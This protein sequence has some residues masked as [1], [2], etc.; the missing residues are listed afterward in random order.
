MPYYDREIIEEINNS[1]SILELMERMGEATRG[2]GNTVS[3][4]CPKCGG[5]WNNSRINTQKNFFKCFR[6]ESLGDKFQ[7]KAINYIQGKFNYSLV[8]A[9]EFL[10][11][12]YRLNLSSKQGYS[13]EEKRTFDIL[14]ETFKFY[15]RCL[16]QS[17][18]LIKRGISK[19]VLL[20]V[21]AG[22]APGGKMLTEHLLKKGFKLQELK[23]MSLVQNN[24]MDVVYKRVI[25]PI[26]KYG[27]PIN[28][29]TRRI[30]EEDYMKHCYYNREVVI[31]GHDDIQDNPDYIDIYEAPINQLVSRT[32]GFP[33][34][35]ATGGCNKFNE[36]HMNFIK[37]KKPKKGVRIIYDSDLNGQGQ[38]GAYQVSK[39]LTENS[40][41]NYVV[42]LPLGKDPANLLT[43]VNGKDKFQYCLEHAISGDEYQAHYIM[44]DMPIT[45]I[46]E[47]L[48]R[49]IEEPKKNVIFNSLFSIE[50]VHN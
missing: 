45:M 35:I 40:I 46:L 11:S 37:K 18:Y 12:E 42:M 39:K 20:K 23:D 8:E 29:Y 5:D 13:A 4:L 3:F 21:N 49:R 44:K 34:G 41:K 15:K 1:I 28:F 6:C 7:G 43:E 38:R 2:R 25:L 30:D 36:A 24:G 9:I 50:K 22:Y 33:I 31:Y 14:N 16:H 32:F 27:K 10:D 48:K 26:Y 17:D 19:E 47:H